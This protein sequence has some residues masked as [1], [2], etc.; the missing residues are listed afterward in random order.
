MSANPWLLRSLTHKFS[1]IPVPSAFNTP[2]YSFSPERGMLKLVYE[3]QNDATTFFGGKAGEPIYLMPEDVEKLPH[4]LVCTLF[5]S[6]REQQ[7]HPDYNLTPDI[8]FEQE[9]GTVFFIEIATRDNGHD[10]EAVVQAARTEKARKY[11]PLFQLDIVSKYNILVVT[12]KGAYDRRGLLRDQWSIDQ[13]VAAY[14]WGMM[15]KQKYFEMFPNEKAQAKNERSEKLLELFQSI[16]QDT[17]DMFDDSEV[18]MRHTFDLRR[19]PDA[20]ELMSFKEYEKNYKM[21]WPDARTDKRVIA[22]VPFATASRRPP[23]AFGEPFDKKVSEESEFWQ[24]IYSYLKLHSNELKKSKTYEELSHEAWLES[25]ESEPS[26]SSKSEDYLDELRLR[27]NDADRIE[28]AKRGVMAKKLIDDARLKLKVEHSK[29]PFSMDGD[30]SHI[31]DWLSS[32]MVRMAEPAVGVYDLADFLSE[33]TYNLGDLLVETLHYEEMHAALFLENI[34][35]EVSYN[36]HRNPKDNR[37]G[38]MF[39]IRPVVG[40]NAY[41]VIRTTRM[42]GSE[43]S[44]CF[45][46]VIAKDVK[47]VGPF[48]KWFEI[49]EGWSRTD[50]VSTNMK[51]A[52]QT[53][54][55]LSICVTLV[56]VIHEL[57]LEGIHHQSVAE[58]IEVERVAFRSFIAQYLEDSGQTAETTQL[59]RYYYMELITGMKNSIKD[60]EKIVSKWPEVIR[61]KWLAFLMNKWKECHQQ[62]DPDVH[63][64]VVRRDPQDTGPILAEEEEDPDEVMQQEDVEKDLLSGSSI[65]T[66]FGFQAKN[67]QQILLASY[68]CVIHNKG[69]GNYLHG[70]LQ[71]IDKMLSTAAKAQKLIEEH[72]SERAAFIRPM[73]DPAKMSKFQHCPNS[74]AKGVYLLKKRIAEINHVSPADWERWIQNK[75][76]DYCLVATLTSVCTTKAT[77]VPFE[78]ESEVKYQGKKLEGMTTRRKVFEE[79]FG[80]LDDLKE[81]RLALNLKQIDYGLQSD[82]GGRIL[83]TIFKKT[84]IGIREILVLTVWGRLAIK[85]YQDMYRAIA[86]LHPSEKLMNE[87]SRSTFVQEH[88]QK[89]ASVRKTFNATLKASFDKAKW[90]PSFT[91]HEFNTLNKTILPKALRPFARRILKAHKRKILQLPRDLIKSFLSE[92]RGDELSSVEIQKIRDEFLGK[93]PASR[94]LGEGVPNFRLPTDMMMGILH[95]TSSVYHVAHMELLGSIL[96]DLF[97]KK[98][99]GVELTFSFEVSSDDEG[100][101]FTISCDDKQLLSKAIGYLMARFKD[102]IRSVD[103]LFGIETSEAKSTW[104]MSEVFEFNSVFMSKNTVVAPI[105]KFALAATSQSVAETLHRQVSGLYS[106]LNQLRDNGGSGFLC[107]WVAWSQALLHYRNLGWGTMDW[108]KK[109]LS[110]MFPYKTSAE[111]CYMIGSPVV[112]G[113]VDGTYMNYV[114][115]T[116]INGADQVLTKMCSYGVP[117]DIDD[118]DSGIMRVYPT[119]KYKSVLK[120]MGLDDETREDQLTTSNFEMFLR[121]SLS[122]EEERVKMKFIILS[123]GTAASMTQLTKTHKTRMTPYLLW[124]NI[125]KKADGTHT[126]R[127]EILKEAIQKT[128]ALPIRM[129][130]PMSDHLQAVR[131]FAVVQHNLQR[132]QHPKRTRFVWVQ[133]YYGTEEHRENFKEILRWKWYGYRKESG[134]GSKMEREWL[135]L[136]EELPFLSTNLKETFERSPFNS[137]SQLLG[138]IENYSGKKNSRKVLMRGSRGLENAAVLGLSRFNTSSKH[139]MLATKSETE[140]FVDSAFSTEQQAISYPL[141]IFVQKTISRMKSWYEIMRGANPSE[142]VIVLSK[143]R[144]DIKWIVETQC[145]PRSL[146]KSTGNRL[147]DTELSKILAM[148][149]KINLRELWDRSDTMTV[150]QQVQTRSL[151]G[152]F[153]GDAKAYVKRSG[154]SAYCVHNYQQRE[155]IAYSDDDYVSLIANLPSRWRPTAVLRGKGP[156]AP[157]ALDCTELKIIDG[158]R[159]MVFTDPLAFHEYYVQIPWVSPYAETH[160]VSNPKHS[161]WIN[162]WLQRKALDSKNID[163]LILQLST[164]SDG[165]G[166]LCSASVSFAGSLA[167]RKSLTQIEERLGSAK[168][169]KKKKSESENIDWDEYANSIMSALPSADL[170]DILEMHAESY[171]EMIADLINTDYD[172]HDYAFQAEPADYYNHSVSLNKT[173][174]KLNEFVEQLSLVMSHLPLGIATIINTYRQAM[175]KAKQEEAENAESE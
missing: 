100:M 139:A 36:M 63:L 24:G 82:E 34:I 140:K 144:D 86:Q 84:Q 69:E 172:T 60:S 142:E 41:V 88:N 125:Y 134:T 101:L 161:D 150:Y 11:A 38:S 158:N 49:G 83:V 141:R 25:E 156:K 175:H 68:I 106:S 42:S 105:I 18:E 147:L 90:A 37:D 91:L 27:I 53:V 146:R 102:I 8:C 61:S 92:K 67:M 129:L 13:C 20:P 118:V 137:L 135:M 116:T 55:A 32:P 85:I 96:N 87:S 164:D 119:R 35:R 45:F 114:A 173:F 145:D 149:G 153:V 21:R 28:L 15:V 152:K 57:L 76:L 103:R 30:F 123:P 133:P 10:S 14:S 99:E 59:L 127:D 162:S 154:T 117:N 138:F 75:I 5:S 151:S 136:R 148:T 40:F 16:E 46:A 65:P 131:S 44:P 169:E 29:L 128:N 66:P 33:D 132:L 165:E 78:I 121:E 130:F 95:Y 50:F 113:I 52:E 23:G 120:R 1:E 17:D 155:V 70:E 47:P 163:D 126:T 174:R 22:H 93:A 122:V 48:E 157:D 81:P 12:H 31:E 167:A 89:V 26:K 104:S 43:G 51:K 108:F 62:V 2:K 73:G 97:K 124:S 115:A 4:D 79:L 170:D 160:E 98:F 39:I 107:H 74:V 94:M 111:G 80:K 54:S 19:F 112:A 71:I 3:T 143:M 72:G 168:P 110:S 171:A 159:V 56:G 166:A 77:T 7:I 58:N 9:D 64:A 6:N 109:D